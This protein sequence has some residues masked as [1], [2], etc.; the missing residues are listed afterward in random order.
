MS[1]KPKK[2]T[3]VALFLSRLRPLSAAVLRHACRCLALSA[4]VDKHKPVTRRVVVARYSLFFFAILAV[5]SIKIGYENAIKPEATLDFDHVNAKSQLRL[6]AV[7][8]AITRNQ[9]VSAPMFYGEKCLAYRVTYYLTKIFLICVRRGEV[10][11][12]R[13]V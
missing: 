9:S 1:N 10:H 6:L 7:V 13:F 3:V 8:M 11:F 5:I 4:A 12:L 2:K